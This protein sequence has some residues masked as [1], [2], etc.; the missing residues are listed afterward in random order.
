MMMMITDGT[1]AE[2]SKDDA[3]AVTEA[4]AGGKKR[5]TFAAMIFSG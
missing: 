2:A 5:T 3:T 1:D 4:P